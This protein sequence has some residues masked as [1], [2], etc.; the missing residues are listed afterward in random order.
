LG[1]FL[2]EISNIFRTLNATPPQ[3]VHQK[4]CTVVP[5]AMS[6]ITAAT[7]VPRGFAAQFPTKYDFNEEEFAR[8]SELA[9]LQ[10]EDAQEDLDEAKT[11]DAQPEEDKKEAKNGVAPMQTAE[12]VL[13]L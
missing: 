2:A 5:G 4:N 10:L 6:M 11:E 1:N 12:Y 3:L 8:I 13:R 9:K 7:W